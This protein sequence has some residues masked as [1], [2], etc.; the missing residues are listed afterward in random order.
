VQKI[1]TA[2]IGCGKVGHIFAAAL[3]SM[4]E[5][6]FVAVCGRN[7]A[8]TQ[9]FADKYNV[10]A[11]DDP[12][13]MIRDT[14]A[15]AI[16]IGTQHP[17][18]AGP[19]VACANAGAHVLI[20]K[21]LAST[22]AD[23]DLILNAAK[24]NNTI[25]STISQRRFY[26]CSQR[27]RNAIDSGKI[28][29][30]ILGVATMFGWR[31]EKYYKSDPWRGSWAG[32]GGGILVNQAPHQLDLLNWYMGPIA[33]LSGYWANLNHP[34]IEVE[35]TAVAILRFKSGALGHILMTNSANPALYGRVQING[36]NGASVG[37]QTDGG[38]MFI[39][40]MS[41]IAEPPINDVWTIPGEE[42]LLAQWKKQDTDHF[43]SI[44]PI[45]HFHTLQI[46][47][48][49]NAIKEKRQPYITGQDGRRTV[50]L[51]TAIY[52]SNKTKAPVTF[53]LPPG[54]DAFR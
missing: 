39:A 15:Q 21:P 40:G 23:C 49:L 35:D 8:R 1:K 11:F 14:G 10:K 31:D 4:P 32:E 52:R 38:A 18:H 13:K 54:D 37:V 48:F 41:K 3:K 36:S 27:I 43:N 17:Q 24:Q 42:H 28:G 26:D 22:L 46:R 2:L 44:D 25:V 33:E 16:C 7:L 34:Y 6:D 45:A 53:P 9:P 51:F 29:K 5:S 47:D 12:T 50:E 20:E 19:A 30:P